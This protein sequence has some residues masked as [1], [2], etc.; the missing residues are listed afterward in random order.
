MTKPPPA[1]GPHTKTV[2]DKEFNWCPK[3]NSWGRHKASECEGRGTQNP[4]TKP[5]PK[6]Q[7][8]A[9]AA[10][11]LKFKNSLEAIATDSD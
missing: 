7:L 10:K 8:N 1:G 5:G 3:H 11:Q 2:D 4:A 9:Q 6:T